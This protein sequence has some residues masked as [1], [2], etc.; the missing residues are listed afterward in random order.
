[1]P[2]EKSPVVGKP[3]NELA[4]PESFA[5][6]RWRQI[7]TACGRR[8]TSFETA[9]AT[10]RDPSKAVYFR[11]LPI[12]IRLQIYRYIYGSHP[13][14]KFQQDCDM[15]TEMIIA[16]VPQSQEAANILLV[17]KTMYSEAISVALER[18]TCEVLITSG[19][20]YLNF[21]MFKD[22]EEGCTADSNDRTRILSLVPGIEFQAIV[23]PKD[24]LKALK[25]IRDDLRLVCR[26]RARQSKMEFVLDVYQP[27]R[28]AVYPMPPEDADLWVRCITSFL[29]DLRCDCVIIQSGGLPRLR[30][31]RHQLS[32]TQ[33]RQEPR[34]F[35]NKA[36]AD[37]EDQY[38]VAGVPLLVSSFLTTASSVPKEGQKHEDGQGNQNQD[39][40]GDTYGYEDGKV[41]K[42]SWELEGPEQNS[43]TDQQPVVG[44]ADGLE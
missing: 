39:Q 17:D 34:G 9:T 1:M 13:V 2:E 36:L 41:F 8:A 40:E 38:S 19:A 10:S 16:P 30:Q 35:R 32:I 25:V 24:I 26:R 42:T 3:Q 27:E 28:G 12:E 14:L 21:D 44:D 15:P 7:T 37:F 4:L 20:L 6:A 18:L 23:P 11:T 5:V 43:S 33:P 22:L 29:G 31:R